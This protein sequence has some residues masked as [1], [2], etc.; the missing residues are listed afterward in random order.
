MKLEELINLLE[1]SPFCVTDENREVS[2]AYCG[3]LLSDVL[4]HLDDGD[5][6]FTIQGHVN[7]VAVAQLRD[8]ACIVLTNGVTPDPQTVAK[9]RTMDVSIC[10]SE[11]TSASLCMELAQVLQRQTS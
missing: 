8:A 1:L 7:I 11:K 2:G 9:A 10:G 3:D 4:A 6:W 5:V